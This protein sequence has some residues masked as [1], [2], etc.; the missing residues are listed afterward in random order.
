MDFNRLRIAT[1][2]WLFIAVIMVLLVGIAGIGLV[3]S[4]GILA[5]GRAQQLVD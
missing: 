4:A 2:L 5:Q 1:K 3:R